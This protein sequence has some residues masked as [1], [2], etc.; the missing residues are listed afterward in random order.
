MVSART[1]AA[2]W[3]AVLEGFASPPPDYSPAPLWWWSGDP[4]RRERLRWQMEQLRAGG[5]YQAV[6]IHLAGTGPYGASDADEP[7]FLSP[8]WWEIVQGVCEDA[9]ELGMKL[10]FYDQ[11]GFASANIKERLVCQHP[12]FSGWSL[13]SLVCEGTGE[14]SLTC[15]AE[16]EPLAA[17][18]IPLGPDG[19]PLGEAV[20]VPLQ[21]PT[22]RATQPG[23]WRL[24][25]M[26]VTRKGFDTLNP[27]ACQALFATI[28][29]Q[30]E[31]HLKPYFGSVVMGTFQDE[32]PALP[33]WCADF[34]AAFRRRKGYDLIA[35]LH[36][37]WEGNT[38]EAWLT[39]ID[40]QAVRAELAQERFFRPLADWHRRHGLLSGFDQM[41]GSRTGQPIDGVALYADY[42]ATHR[43]FSAPGCDHHGEG[44]VHS[45]LAHLY[46]HPRTWLEAFHSSGWGSTLEETFDWLL[47]WFRAGANLYN[48]HAV[49]YSTRGG[50]WEWAPPS[51]CWRQPY[52]RHYRLF[53]QAVSRL[54]FLLTRGHHV[55]Q[56]AV[57]HPTLCAQ[58][59]WA[60]GKV[61]PVAQQA[62]ETY[63]SLVGSMVWERPAP[64]VLDQAGLDF[65]VLDEA[66]LQRGRAR[67]GAL[68]L[69]EE[70]YQAILLPACQ[71]LTAETARALCQFVAA[72][73]LLVAVGPLPCLSVG[74]PEP[75]D[76]LLQLFRSGQARHVATPADVAAALADLPRPVAAPVPT[77]HRQLGR[78]HLL[79]VPAAFPRVTEHATSGDRRFLPYTF[80]PDRYP[81]SLPVRLRGSVHRL[82][83][84]DVMTGERQPLPVHSVGGETQVDVPFRSA[85]AAVLVWEEEDTSPTP[86][87][88]PAAAPGADVPR[89]PRPT[90]LDQPG[91]TDQASKVPP[92]PELPAEERWLP[93]TWRCVVEPTLDNRYG[94]FA[95]PAGGLVGVQ[96]WFF[97]HRRELPGHDGLQ[98]GWPT[99][100]E[101]N[102]WPEV[103]ATYG[104]YGWW[105]G[106]ST[107]LPEPLA[108]LQPG[109]DPL[110]V[111]GWRPLV[112]SLSHGIPRDTLHHYFGP[113]GHVP[114]EFM[115]FGEVPAGAGVQV[116]T[117]LW[118]AAQGEAFLCVGAPA[119]KALWVNG[120]LYREETPGYLWMPQVSLLPGPNV[121]EIRLMAAERVRLRAYWALVHEPELFARPEIACTADAP[122]KDTWVTFRRE[123]HLPFRPQTAALRLTTDVESRLLV[124]GRLLARHGGY[125][126]W[127][128]LTRTQTYP[129]PDLTEGR[130]VIEVQARDPGRTVALSVD[131]RA[132]GPEGQVW[133][134]TTAAGWTYQRADGPP[135]PCQVRRQPWE[136]RAHSGVPVDPAWTHLWRR[137]HPLPAA[138]WLEP[139]PAHAGVELVVPDAFP[140]LPR[141]E[142]FQWRLPP[143]AVRMHLTVAG[144]WQLWVD[145]RPV[146][147]DGET[148]PL[149]HPEAPERQ[150]VLR[151]VPAPG[152]SAGA[153]FRAPITYDLTEGTIRL[154][155]WAQQGLASY[156]GAVRYRTAFTLDRWWGNRL[157]L[158]L[159]RVRGTA[160]VWLNG[161]MVGTR[162]GSPYR[163]DLTPAITS[164]E[165]QLEVVV[166]NTLA[167]YLKAASPT[168]Y[169]LPGQDLSGLLGPVRLLT[170]R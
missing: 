92:T 32:L 125:S 150:A 136:I 45:S 166:C 1:S 61:Y 40:Y 7:P 46:G 18:G 24:R 22:A 29:G 13:E 43:G 78:H 76:R 152:R 15:P 139:D 101:A 81:A 12:S 68:W 164:G 10:W 127:T 63:R 87:A 86:P 70:R 108:T 96:T 144:E 19:Q 25:L 129:L 102:S 163:F 64:G 117:T 69:G 58:A 121:L 113:R 145:G 51:T 168:P 155:P 91:E 52:W 146:V 80:D 140:G 105:T 118:R 54:C 120:R 98:G 141:V 42:L 35:R 90:N 147:A 148:V 37:L 17:V 137:P 122:R 159:G 20:P 89:M 21:G 31:R 99:D 106:P 75:L 100:L 2:P 130:N 49:Y 38:P 157:E 66:S 85:P 167:P 48:P 56:V 151:V 79:Y 65:D 6:I 4:L 114:E 138:A 14:L 169:V 74:D 93:D 115:D 27:K 126:P 28:H 153:V 59:G 39:R 110:A 104:V 30:L 116:R 5:V 88:A 62:Q 133:T 158:D 103:Q 50:W 73:G 60:M 67:D 162:I 131:L 36:H 165:N 132:I 170:Y 149:P 53:A 82:E 3:D 134:A 41:G 9:R 135:L 123:L 156:A 71:V 33:S 107:H 26:Y 160:E 83:L 109:P 77:L 154:G 97:G 34:A 84:W 161:Q 11:I 111:Q 124:N 8:E 112:Y 94:D 128:D 16:G 47:P 95:Q 44:K 55:C 57:L 119:I 143:G 142:W 23:R 72:G